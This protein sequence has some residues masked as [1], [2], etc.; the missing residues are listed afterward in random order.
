MRWAPT[1][2]PQRAAIVAAVRREP[3]MSVQGV[4]R[5]LGVDPSTAD[6]HLRRLARAGALVRRRRGRELAHFVPGAVA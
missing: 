5:A 3:G 1:F 4:A 2:T 6:Y